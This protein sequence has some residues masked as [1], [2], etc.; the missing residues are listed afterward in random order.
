MKI[1]APRREGMRG[2]PDTHWT[3]AEWSE[4]LKNSEGQPLL[5]HEEWQAVFNFNME[6]EK[7]GVCQM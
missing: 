2:E 6:V 4:I 7:Q 5:T 3:V 1:K